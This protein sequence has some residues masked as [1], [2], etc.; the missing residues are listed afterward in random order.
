MGG[1]PVKSLDQ[2]VE[3][4]PEVEAQVRKVAIWGTGFVGSR[5][6]LHREY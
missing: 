2:E 6:L 3:R 4:C 5:D 1:S